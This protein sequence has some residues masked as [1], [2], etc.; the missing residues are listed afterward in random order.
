MRQRDA[1]PSAG[2]SKNES[3]GLCDFTLNPTA[4]TGRSVQGGERAIG[5]CSVLRFGGACRVRRS[6]TPVS[7]AGYSLPSEPVHIHDQCNRHCDPI[8]ECEGRN[9]SADYTPRKRVGDG[10]AEFDGIANVRR[11]H[12]G[13]SSAGCGR[14][15]AS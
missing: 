9:D 11:R 4:N 1:R 2:L 14:G 5:K 3:P 10:V 7:P 13:F 12:A 15:N 8:R 6:G